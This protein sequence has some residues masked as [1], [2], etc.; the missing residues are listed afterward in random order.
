MTRD[1]AACK[2]YLANQDQLCYA[3]LARLEEGTGRGQRI[4]DVCNGTGLQF[5]VT[6]DRAMNLVECSF[7]GIPIAFRA[8]P[9]HRG[10]SGDW[11]HNWTAGMMTTAGL[12]NIGS[13]SGDQPLHGYISGE[14]AEHL[15]LA[16]RDGEIAVSGVLR[17]GAIF[18]AA[19][20]LERAITTGYGRNRITIRDRVVNDS[21]SP[22]FTE[23]LYHCNFGYPLVS[24]ALVFDAPEHEIEA[25]DEAAAAAQATWNRFPEP[26]AGFNE[27]C[28]RHKLPADAAGYA[29]MRVVNPELGIAVRVGFRADTLRLMVEWQKPSRNN[30]VLGL[31]PTNGSLNGCEYDRANGYGVTLPPGG[32]VEYECFLEFERV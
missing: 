28:Y 19:L 18:D 12:R 24:P 16:C 5:T 29:S 30:Y 32:E 15:S 31:E 1:F 10:T 27:Y 13:P 25:R 7:L 22:T 11:L 8:S 21:E 6:P 3:R 4:V 14:A 2:P 23:I 17:E 9:G 20:R 26:L